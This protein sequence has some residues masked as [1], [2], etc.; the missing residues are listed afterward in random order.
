MKHFAVCIGNQGYEVSLEKRKF[1]EYNQDSLL[2]ENNLIRIIDES[3]EG[4]IYPESLFM[5]IDI[6]IELVQKLEYA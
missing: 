5:K 3:G 6:P 1:Y 2:E 4:Y